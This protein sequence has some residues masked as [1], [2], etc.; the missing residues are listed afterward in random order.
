VL[1]RPRRQLATGLA[2]LLAAVSWAP[3]RPGARPRSTSSQRTAV[4]KITSALRRAPPLSRQDARATITAA[5]LIPRIS[6]A[7]RG[8][9][10]VSDLRIT[11]LFPC[12]AR[13]FDDRYNLTFAGRCWRRSPAAEGSSGAPRGHVDLW[14]V[15]KVW[16]YPCL[17]PTGANSAT[18]GPGSSRP[19]SRVRSPGTFPGTG[20][21][22]VT[23][24]LDETGSTRTMTD[25]EQ[26][27]PHLR[28]PVT[29]CGIFEPRPSAFQA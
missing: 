27:H 10:L 13:R 17:L 29:G 26:T 3:R 6:R 4:F 19:S 20:C 28:T 8:G 11:S 5:G 21:P 16:P 7:A 9:Q 12:V 23:D 24:G 2:A 22:A 14:E 25:R 15:L 1:V 18:L